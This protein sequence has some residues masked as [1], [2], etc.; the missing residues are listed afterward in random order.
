MALSDITLACAECASEFQF[1]VGEQEFHASRGF[2]NYPKRCSACRSAHRNQ[3]RDGGGQ[4]ESF[5][6][7][8]SNCGANATVPFQPRGDRPVY[9]G[10]CFNRMR[11]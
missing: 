5:S 8:C 3:S 7:V 4:R 2:T 1:T 6:I 9:C 10:D 11:E